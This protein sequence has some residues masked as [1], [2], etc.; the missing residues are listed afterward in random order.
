MWS[1]PN[2]PPF[3]DLLPP[4]H[5]GRISR[6]FRRMPLPRNLEK[7]HSLWIT[8]GIVVSRNIGAIHELSARVVF[9]L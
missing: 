1:L 9:E 6:M 3:E 8:S 2:R 4:W 7:L 5:S